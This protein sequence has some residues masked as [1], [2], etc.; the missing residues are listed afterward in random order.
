ML[1]TFITFD[2]KDDVKKQLADI[3]AA[4]KHLSGIIDECR[5]VPGMKQKHFVMD[6]KTMAQ[7]AFLVW[8]TEEHFKA[9][10]KSDLYKATVT[11]ICAGKP[12]IE[13]YVY[14]AN[15]KDG[16]LI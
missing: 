6:P 12:R 3:T 16:L 1:A 8:D 4:K 5:K 2:V 15:L 9:Y 10:L 14:S 11:D 13:A 7:G